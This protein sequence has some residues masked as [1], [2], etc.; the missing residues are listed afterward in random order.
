[1]SVFDWR[2]EPLKI[3]LKSIKT[4]CKNSYQQSQVVNRKRAAGIEPSPSVAVRKIALDTQRNKPKN[5]V[6]ELPILAKYKKK[7]KHETR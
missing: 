2:N 1:M 3:D 7:R 5:I 4:S 6:V